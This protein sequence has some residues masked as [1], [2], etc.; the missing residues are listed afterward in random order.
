MEWTPHKLSLR[1]RTCRLGQMTPEERLHYEQCTKPVTA[2]EWIA[3]LRR[4][5]DK[6]RFWNGKRWSRRLRP[7]IT[8]RRFPLSQ[9][10]GEISPKL[11]E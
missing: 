5:D 3:W 11:P 4:N 1:G 9:F 8:P 2:S 7:F 10:T 6:T